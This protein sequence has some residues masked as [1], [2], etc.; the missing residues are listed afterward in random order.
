MMTYDITHI[1][2]DINHVIDYLKFS[3]PSNQS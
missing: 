2:D 1:Y 3:V